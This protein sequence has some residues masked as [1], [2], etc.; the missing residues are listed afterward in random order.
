M[1]FYFK[2]PAEAVLVRLSD[3]PEQPLTINA[4]MAWAQVVEKKQLLEVQFDKDKKRASLI[5]AS[6]NSSVN[7][8]IKEMLFKIQLDDEDATDDGKFNIITFC[9]CKTFVLFLSVEH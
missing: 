8:L 7:N 3:V 4:Y 6:T 9:T 2:L 5:S 1:C